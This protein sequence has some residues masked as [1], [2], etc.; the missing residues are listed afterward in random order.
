MLLANRDGTKPANPSA[1]S[2][3]SHA[4]GQPGWVNQTDLEQQLQPELNVSVRA[5]ASN[6]TR[7][8]IEVPV[9]KPQIRVIEVRMV[10]KVEH[11]RAEL[12]LESFG[13]T[14]RPHDGKVDIPEVRTAQCIHS[15]IPE[16]AEC[17]QR[18]RGRVIPF[19]DC[20]RR[21]AIGIADEVGA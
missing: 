7:D 13:D 19:L 6:R 2:G 3:G 8:R 10:E 12:Q 20:V 4:E 15:R 17:W 18:K 21:P 14:E 11:L 5:R 1:C 9:T 16:G